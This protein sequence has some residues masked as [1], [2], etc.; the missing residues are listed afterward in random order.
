[1]SN[2]TAKIP[3][4]ATIWARKTTDSEIF[5][6]KPDKWFKIWFYLVNRVNH[7]TVKK[8]SRGECFII[9]TE[10]EQQTGA[11]PDQV[12]KCLQ[13]L[14][15]MEMIDTTRSTRGVTLKILNY[16]HYQSLDNYESKTKSTTTGTREAPEKHQ[17]STPINKNDKNV[18]NDKN[19]I[20]KIDFSIFWNL[21]DKKTDKVWCENKWNSLKLSEQQEITRTLPSY[22]KSTFTN[23]KFPS[24]KNPK[25]YLN[26]KC[27]EDEVE[28]KKIIW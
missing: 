18:K 6:N 17:R 27:W 14:N 24:R 26:N 8:W 22:V 16:S 9:Y 21:Y 12:K 13:Y 19:N 5:Y 4:G 28:E 15:K 10:I 2:E 1:M 3:G 20:K 11:T 25:T 7:K 23:G